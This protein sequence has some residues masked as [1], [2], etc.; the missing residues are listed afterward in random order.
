MA[1]KK[2]EG[3]GLVGVFF[4]TVYALVSRSITVTRQQT[5]Q[6]SKAREA[7]IE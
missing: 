2:R 1:K 4:N 6:F 5:Q 7:E 3:R